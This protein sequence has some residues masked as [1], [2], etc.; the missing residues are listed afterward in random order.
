[1]GLSGK[2]FVDEGVAAYGAAGVNG[3][4]ESAEYKNT[5]A[6]ILS[7]IGA[8]C[9]KCFLAEGDWTSLA[10]TQ[11]IIPDSARVDARFL[12]HQ[13]NDEHRWPRSGSAQPFIKPSDVKAQIVWLPDLD[14][15]RRVTRVLDAASGI[16][17]AIARRSRAVDALKD[18]LLQRTFRAAK[19]DN[20]PV[21]KLGE[22]SSP[23][24]WPT[25]SRAQMTP[26][27]FPV[28]GANGIIG[29]YDKFNHESPTLLVG[30]RGT[31]GSV[32]ITKARAYVTGNAMALDDLQED[33]V[34]MSYVAAFLEWRGFRD[35]TS[36]S[37]QP[38]LT[39][40]SVVNTDV[41]VL[42]AEDQRKVSAIYQGL[43]EIET[44]QL[45]EST[46]GR[47][48]MQAVRLRT[49]RI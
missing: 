28:Y 19:L 4:V 41:P 37:S 5:A 38:Q 20:Y 31:I 14:E 35:V 16:Q 30:C 7:A 23:K 48:L 6:I 39:R 36:G 44:M 8:R 9:G 27:G 22:V 43:R 13:L 46:L 1:M 47:E 17:D 18:K 10:N 45:R 2:D 11:V 34:T 24:Q 29:F 12:W 40:A 15:Q 3:R 32:H 25:V 26:E 42:P 21:V 49:I 33:V